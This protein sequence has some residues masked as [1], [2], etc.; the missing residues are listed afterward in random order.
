MSTLPCTSELTYSQDVGPETGFSKISAAEAKKSAFDKLG[1][2]TKG[3][4]TAMEKAEDKY[5]CE[6]TDCSIDATA[7]SIKPVIIREYTQNGDF[8]CIAKYSVQMKVECR[9]KPDLVLASFTGLTDTRNVLTDL[10]SMKISDVS[11]LAQFVDELSAMNITTVADLLTDMSS[12]ELGTRTFNTD[13]ID[14][15]KTLTRE[16][17]LLQG[18]VDTLTDNIRTSES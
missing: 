5:S 17:K 15:T 14:S 3:R 4:T 18:K 7:L 8:Y 11:A 10:A 9:K 16:V 2:Y 1:G 12:E 13:M 6:G